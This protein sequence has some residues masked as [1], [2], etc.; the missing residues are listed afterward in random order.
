MC[1]QV[2]D[3][4]FRDDVRLWRP[5]GL[6]ELQP[7]GGGRG[8]RNRGVSVAPDA[9]GGL[10]DL[11]ASIPLDVDG[12]GFRPC[13]GR[14]SIPPPAVLELE[15][16]DLSPRDG[17]LTCGSAILHDALPA[18]LDRGNRAL[19]DEA[20]DLACWNADRTT[21]ADAAEFSARDPGSDRVD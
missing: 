7:L 11:P 18:V 5:G 16:P 19:F 1:L 8:E 10:F 12:E 2:P 3:V 21:E 6:L 15:P 13:A 4:G 20:R 14:F 9:V 17:R